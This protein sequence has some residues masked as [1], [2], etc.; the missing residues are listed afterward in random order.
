MRHSLAGITTVLAATA[1]V[2]GLGTVKV[3]QPTHTSTHNVHATTSYADSDHP[4]SGEGPN[5]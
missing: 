1:V 4:G 2:V 3:E 5:D